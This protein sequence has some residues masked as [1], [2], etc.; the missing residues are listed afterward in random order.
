MYRYDPTSIDTRRTRPIRFSSLSVPEVYTDERAKVQAN[1]A[2]K[3]S[4]ASSQPFKLRRA[5]APGASFAN[6]GTVAS[7]WITALAIL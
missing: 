7:R 1:P 4:D 2:S 3:S 5:E 6:G